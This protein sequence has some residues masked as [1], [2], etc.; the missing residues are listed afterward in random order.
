MRSITGMLRAAATT[1]VA[2]V[3][4]AG[5]AGSAHA[6]DPPAPDVIYPDDQ[7]K[8]QVYEDGYTTGYFG[9]SDD[10]YTEGLD[11][12]FDR[13]LQEGRLQGRADAENEADLREDV[14]DEAEDDPVVEGGEDLT[15][16][17]PAPTPTEPVTYAEPPQQSGGIPWWPLSFAVAATAWF[18]TRRRRLDAESVDAGDLGD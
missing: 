16:S 13:G 9:G 1:I 2:A 17:T 15:P 4:L 18:V 6:A 11:T 5:V 10:G 7:A 3:L 8:Q 12:G 14:A